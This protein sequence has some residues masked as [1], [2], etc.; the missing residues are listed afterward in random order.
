M[1]NKYRIFETEE[2]LKK[3]EKSE[4]QDEIFIQNKLRTYIYPQIRSEPFFGKNIKKLKGYVPET[5]RYRIGKFRLFYT[6]DQAESI[7]YILTL[8]DRK[9][10]YR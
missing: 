10:A 2:F 3:L 7:I 6:V 4:Q 5:Y 8:N 9:D 1:S